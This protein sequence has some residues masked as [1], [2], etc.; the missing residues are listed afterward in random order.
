MAS[1]KRLKQSLITLRSSVKGYPDLVVQPG[2]DVDIGRNS[3]CKITD[4]RCPKV[5]V[6]IRIETGGGDG[7]VLKS[8]N[9]KTMEE[10]VYKD[11][12]VLKG[13]GYSY[14]V[15][16]E[17]S[18]SG[19]AKKKLMSNDF[20]WEFDEKAQ[21]HVC[22]FLGGGE[23]SSQIAA[24]DFDGTLSVAKSGFKFPK[25]GAD[26]KLLDKKLPTLIGTLCADGPKRFVMFSNQ[27][28]ILTKAAK[29]E[30]VK[31]R[32]EGIMNEIKI[33]CLAFIA[34]AN[35]FQRKPRPGMFHLLEAKYNDGIVID[36]SSSLYVGDAAGRKGSK[37][38]DHSAADVLLS[39]NLDL[40]FQTP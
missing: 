22:K 6:T 19:P 32:F 39:I 40:P 15:E 35:N 36:K 34:I 30:H 16:L 4:V 18:N 29:L 11:G 21:V 10:T 7:I 12:E 23:A 24:F 3:R 14:T 1:L 38:K 5:S 25:D 9:K 27:L 17:D 37:P 8:T 33:P 20:R 26:F 31:E 13:P 2:E 28:G